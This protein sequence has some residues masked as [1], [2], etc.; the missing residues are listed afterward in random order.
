MLT[1]LDMR[2]LIDVK[3]HNDTFIVRRQNVKL[4]VLLIEGYREL[5]A[6]TKAE[7]FIFS[8]QKTHNKSTILDK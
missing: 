5:Q 3:Q 4:F 6:I 8:Q 7:L 2:T 1:L